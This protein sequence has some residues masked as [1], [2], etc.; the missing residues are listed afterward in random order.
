MTSSS[1][2]EKSCESPFD[3][4]GKQPRRTEV[5]FG[6]IEEESQDLSQAC[7]TLKLIP[8]AASSCSR[9]EWTTTLGRRVQA[10]KQTFA[11]V[12]CRAV[13]VLGKI[14]ICQLQASTLNDPMPVCK[15][16][17]SR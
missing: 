7:V 13:L 16:K 4:E 12:L 15:R 3:T 6:N 17:L 2:H 1:P 9:I 10:S 5:N 8:W 14:S 11:M